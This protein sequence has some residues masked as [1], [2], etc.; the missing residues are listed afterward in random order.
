MVILFL[1]KLKVEPQEET[2]E[3][4]SFWSKHSSVWGGHQDKTTSTFWI[5]VSV[6]QFPECCLSYH[7]YLLKGTW[8]AGSCAFPE[9]MMDTGN[10]SAVSLFGLKSW[11]EFVT[12][13]YR[14]LLILSPALITKFPLAQV[15][16]YHSIE[17]YSFTPCKNTFWKA[18]YVLSL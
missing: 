3:G 8:R 6:S 10:F 7:S 13:S 11:E 18:D 17:L 9:G 1:I 2:Q 15:C 5:D 12:N 4:P 14:C 16:F